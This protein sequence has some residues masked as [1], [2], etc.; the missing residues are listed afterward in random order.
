MSAS[1]CQTR[2]PAQSS[3]SGPCPLQ[4]PVGESLEA[5]LAARLGDLRALLQNPISSSGGAESVAG[6]QAV[7]QQES[8]RKEAAQEAGGSLSAA[9]V[10]EDLKRRIVALAVSEACSM[11]QTESEWWRREIKRLDTAATKVADRVDVL[12]SS[13][14][15]GKSAAIGQGVLKPATNDFAHYNNTS[16]Q[17]SELMHLVSVLGT[18]LTH[19]RTVVS[20]M[21]GVLHSVD[22]ANQLCDGQYC[23]QPKAREQKQQEK[24]TKLANDSDVHPK[25]RLQEEQ[26]QLHQQ[27]L[28]ALQEQVARLQGQLE[29]K[30]NE[31]GASRMIDMRMRFDEV[32]HGLSVERQERQE[33]IRALS[34]KVDSNLARLNGGADD[35]EAQPRRAVPCAATQPSVTPGPAAAA[36]PQDNRVPVPVLRMVSGP[37]LRSTRQERSSTSPGPQR[38]RGRCMPASPVQLQ[39]QLRPQ[40][41]S[42]QQQPQQQSQVQPQQAQQTQLHQ[43][44]QQQTPLQQPQQLQP[45]GQVTQ[46]RVP[47]QVQM[48]PQRQRN[49]SPIQATPGPNL[50]PPATPSGAPPLGS[51]AR[52]TTPSPR[53][54]S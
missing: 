15:G 34:L 47:P 21:R 7:Q 12:E 6:V 28:D 41:P 45:Q 13:A 22:I 36:L 50:W 26:Q 18:D 49:A 17:V 29:A 2:Q 39:R 14:A 10:E 5:R 44:T 24:E 40:Q 48:P 31:D 20:E 1:A 23:H 38:V 8:S 16:E 33:V 19:L 35:P 30:I 3:S 9:V 43:Q 11:V 27:A 54:A 42:M 37:D 52:F 32:W 51:V 25:Q 46:P 4:A 53:L